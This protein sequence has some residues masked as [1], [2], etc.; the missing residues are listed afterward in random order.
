[1][2]APPGGLGLSSLLPEASR[3]MDEQL[4]CEINTG[5]QVLIKIKYWRSHFK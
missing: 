5:F 3:K 1:M 4:T 2:A